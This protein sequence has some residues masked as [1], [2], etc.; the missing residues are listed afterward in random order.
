M[1][2][3]A[4]CNLATGLG[5]SSISQESIELLGVTV[6]SDAVSLSLIW[7]CKLADGE[8]ARRRAA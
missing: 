7:P 8:G 5:G 6:L 3:L 2:S 1:E 4:L